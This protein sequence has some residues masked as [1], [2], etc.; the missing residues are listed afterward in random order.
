[1]KSLVIYYSRGGTTKE[2]VDLL[3]EKA[4]SQKL[5]IVDIKNQKVVSLKDYNRVYIGTGVYGGIPMEISK[6]VQEHANEL[7][8]TE[9]IMFIHALGAE[10]TYKQM[11][12]KAMSPLHPDDYRVFYLGGKAEMAKQNFFIK[13]L[14]KKL[15]KERQLD[16]QYPNTLLKDKIAEL[17]NT[18]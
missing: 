14:M 7:K 2:T 5:D 12:A 6:F 1:M 10:D 11:A 3:K 15:A 17:L 8:K 4:D 13:M 9:V 18:I 16:M